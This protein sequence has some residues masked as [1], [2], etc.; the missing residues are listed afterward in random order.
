M[1]V[2]KY[3]SYAAYRS[4]ANKSHSSFDVLQ[5]FL[6]LGPSHHSNARLMESLNNFQR[7]I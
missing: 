7:E 3:F 1:K 2:M 4:T 6:D 5:I